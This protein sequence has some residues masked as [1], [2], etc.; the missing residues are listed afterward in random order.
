MNA[1]IENLIPE[2]MS[3]EAVMFGDSIKGAEQA[4]EFELDCCGE[5]LC[6]MTP[7]QISKYHEALLGVLKKVPEDAHDTDKMKVAAVG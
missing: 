2:V 6:D 4:N 1:K 3:M 7:S 5:Y